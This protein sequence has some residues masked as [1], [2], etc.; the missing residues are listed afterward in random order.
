MTTRPVPVTLGEEVSAPFV[1]EFARTFDVEE[2]GGVVA[3]LVEA[4]FSGG[5]VAWLNG[6]ELFRSNV[7]PDSGFDEPAEKVETPLWIRATHSGIFYRAFGGLSAGRL[8]A[9][10]N[11]LA[12]R[13]H[14]SPD[15]DASA[16]VF[17]DL[18]LSAHRAAGF[19]KTP[20]LMP[21]GGRG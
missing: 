7:L 2:P 9:T 12:V 4:N 1:W 20:Y 14:R 17:F 19:V 5:M 6:E 18:E 8:R 10:G 11:V 13:V 3:L 16:P 21:A 15:V